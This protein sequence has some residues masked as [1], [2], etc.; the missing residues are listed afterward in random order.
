MPAVCDVCNAPIAARQGI[1]ITANSFNT[2]LSKG[3]GI[4]PANVEMLTSSGVNRVQAI[5][6]LKQQYESMQSDWLLCPGCS[7]Q[8]K[9]LSIQTEF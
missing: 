2:L 3:F 9:L 4:D 7:S 1:A 8:A 5:A 6:L